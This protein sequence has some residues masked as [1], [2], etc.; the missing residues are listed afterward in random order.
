MGSQRVG[1]DWATNMNRHAHA[2]AHTHTPLWNLPVKLAVTSNSWNIIRNACHSESEVDRTLSTPKY[3]RSVFFLTALFI[4]HSISPL[5]PLSSL[6]SLFFCS[7]PLFPSLL[8][9][10]F[11]IGVKFTFTEQRKTDCVT[12]V[13]HFTNKDVITWEMLLLFQN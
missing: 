5:P 13:K 10:S 7:L 2:C 8:Y 12:I 4:Y 9:P 3:A 11:K 1:Q 6:P